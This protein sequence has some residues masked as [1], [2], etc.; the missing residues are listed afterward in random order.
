MLVNVLYTPSAPFSRLSIAQLLRTESRLLE[1]TKLA[2]EA[3][4][5][6]GRGLLDNGTREGGAACDVGILAPE[7]LDGNWMVD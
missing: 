4:D 1:M 6:Q 5:L 3:I 7:A 2:T